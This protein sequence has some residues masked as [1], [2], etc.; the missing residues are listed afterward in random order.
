MN[1]NQRSINSTRKRINNLLGAIQEAAT[2]E[3]IDWTTAYERAEQVIVFGSWALGVERPR[4]DIDVLCVGRGRSVASDRLHIIWMSS[5]RIAEHVRRGSELACHLAAYG[6]WLKGT[7]SV[8][9]HV[10][11]SA[12]TINRRR[13]H[14]DSRMKALAMNWPQLR[15]QFREKHAL[16]VRRDLQRLTLLKCGR[17]NIPAPALDQEWQKVRNRSKCLSE[18]LRSEPNIRTNYA[19]SVM[20]LIQSRGNKQ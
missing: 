8:P 16:K 6:V 10:S 4:S 19:R 15:F 2:L 5:G 12:D 3:G 9:K 18:W 11:P 14:I 7:R 1:S 13:H 17:A 20:R